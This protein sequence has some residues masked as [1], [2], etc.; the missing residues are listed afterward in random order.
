MNHRERVLTALDHREP[1][2]I[3]IDFGAMRSSGIMAIAY[4]RLKKYI[5]ISSTTRLYDIMQQLA[6]PDLQVLEHYGADVAQV[7][8][9]RPAFGIR[10]DRWKE[11]RLQDG[12]RCL[13]PE[14]FEPVRL[15]DGSEELRKD[16]I[17]VARRPAGGY[18]FDR[19]YFPLA[20]ASSLED[21][22]RYEF[23]RF[24]DEELRFIREQ[25]EYWRRTDYAILG[26]FGG[27]ILEAGQ[28]AFGYERF[29][30]LLALDRE[31]VEY[32]LDK[33]AESYISN[34]QHYLPMVEG[35]VD[36]VQ[37]GDDLGT[38]RGLQLS[39]SMYREVIKPRQAR[40]YQYIKE[41]SSAKLF[42]HS[43][44]A[45]S[46]IIDDLIEIGVDILNPIQTSARGM[47]PVELKKRFGSRITFW[48]GGCDTQY[49]LPYASS[50][51]L[52][53]HIK[54]R[55]RIFGPGGGFVFTQI[56]NIQADIPPEKIETMYRTALEYGKYPLS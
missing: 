55:I 22:E 42:L 25:A 17:V 43:C 10:I 12:S 6:E 39:P 18:Y 52:R 28:F 7:H 31:L 23:D 2:R 13:V 51:E 45:I 49:V 48:G 19:A 5:S 34:L 36:I 27:N 16:G 37:V 32:Y 46:E 35:L 41:H 40:V 29:M 8:R 54:E 50:S 38:Q 33:L 1:D 24:T 44:G 30:T 11:W 21:V 53:E 15:T 26:V 47:D 9:L 14:G 56:H 4:N 3:P 20:E